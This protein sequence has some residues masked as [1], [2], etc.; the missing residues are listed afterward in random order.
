MA[1]RGFICASHPNG[2]VHSASGFPKEHPRL[3][4]GHSTPL[5]NVLCWSTVLSWSSCKLEPGGE[6]RL[7]IST[8][9][10]GRPNFLDAARRALPRSDM[11]LYF[12]SGGLISP[13]HF[14]VKLDAAWV[15]DALHRLR[16]AK[17]RSFWR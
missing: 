1:G 2:S 7:P 12:V 14:G 13:N 6:T 4:F 11:T 3:A 17:T 8:N 9:G 10:V 15:S 5:S 16:V